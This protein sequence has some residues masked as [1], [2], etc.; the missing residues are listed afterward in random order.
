MEVQ[1]KQFIKGFNDG[2][3]VAEHEPELASQL[4]KHLNDHNEYFK[5]VVSG[6]KEFQME[7]VREQLKGMSRNNPPAKDI[8][9]NKGKER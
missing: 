1:E 3:L 8:N 2:Y 4:S 5:G 9:K 7:K 6:T